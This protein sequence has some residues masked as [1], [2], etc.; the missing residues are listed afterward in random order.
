MPGKLGF[1]LARPDGVVSLLDGTSVDPIDWLKLY[2]DAVE[3]IL[4]CMPTL[5]S[6]PVMTR[7]YV[8]ANYASNLANRRS[9]AGILIC[10][11]NSPILWSSKRQNTVET[12]SFSSKIV[13]LHITIEMVEALRHKLG[14]FGVPFDS[15]TK[16][17]CDNK[18]ILT[19]SSVPSLTLNKRHNAICYYRVCEP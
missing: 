16:V 11:N 18:S 10:I 3:E 4:H 7:N 9:R 5:L 12:S 15:P 1:A 13:A 14:Y 17:L 19:N 2:P 8:D 6:T